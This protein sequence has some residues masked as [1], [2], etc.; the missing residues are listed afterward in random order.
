[1]AFF[2]SAIFANDQPTKLKIQLLA[3]N[4]YQ[5]IS[6]KEVAPYG[7]VAASGLVVV[8]GNN[9][10]II[11]TPWTQEDTEHLITWIQA[12]GLTIKS[13]VASHFHEDAS[14]G[15]PLLNKAQIKTYATP[16]TNHLLS[17]NDREKSSDEIT[18]NPFELVKNSIEIFYPGAGHTQDNIVVWLPKAKIL[19]GGCFVKSRHSKP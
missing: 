2:S 7:M 14:S 9:A 4:V 8:D 3:E 12:K 17:L 13:G 16:L 1:M 19:F 15:I 5:H 18:S 6:Y 11:D 10:H